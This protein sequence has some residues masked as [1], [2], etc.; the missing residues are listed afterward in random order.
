MQATI[1]PADFGGPAKATPKQREAVGKAAVAEAEGNV[2]PAAAA[3]DVSQTQASAASS[4]ATAG[5]IETLTPLEAEDKQLDI[6]AKADK[7][8]REA[9]ARAAA[10]RA[11]ATQAQERI[12]TVLEKLAQARRLVSN[13]STGYGSLLSGLPTTDARSLKGILGPEGTIGSQILLRTMDE[14]RQGSA[15]GATG[16]G[17]MDRNENAT[18]KS[19]I[20]SLDLG[21]SPEEVLQSINEILTSVKS[22]YSSVSFRLKTQKIV[23]AYRLGLS[24]AQPRKKM[25]CALQS[26]VALT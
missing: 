16:L 21:R 26:G 9:A 4:R 17:A 18:L 7:A 19:S 1:N 14:L 8:A 11:K 24:A 25:L 12:N 2:A 3:A 6:Q 5:R 20:S 22:R 23:A 13:F 10:A 15:A